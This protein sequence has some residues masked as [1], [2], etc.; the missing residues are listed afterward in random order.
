MVV[1]LGKIDIQY[2]FR[3]IP[4]HPEDHRLLAMLWKDMVY[5]DTSLPFGLWSALK[6]FNSLADA[7]QWVMK[8][9]GSIGWLIT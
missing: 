1:L 2:P 4:V 3:I 6:L 5:I 7:L 9:K 8:K